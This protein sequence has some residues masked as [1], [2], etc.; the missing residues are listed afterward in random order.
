MIN[1]GVIYESSIWYE[2]D[3]DLLV[4]KLQFLPNFCLSGISEI[5][6]ILFQNDQNIHIVHE[7]DF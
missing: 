7:N 6:L 3:I 4:L 1:K 2:I 5:I